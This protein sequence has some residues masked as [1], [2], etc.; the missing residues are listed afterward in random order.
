MADAARELIIIDVQEKGVAEA[1]QKTGKLLSNLDKLDAAQ[2]K[3]AASSDKSS[4]AHERAAAARA[5]ADAAMEKANRALDANARY[6]ALQQAATDAASGS[7][8]GMASAQQRVVDATQ[9]ATKAAN[10]NRDAVAQQGSAFRDAGKFIAEHP[11]LVLGAS[12]AAARALAGLATSAAGS[13]GAASASTAAFAEGAAGMG[14]AVVASAALAA[15]GLSGLSTGATA[16]AAG[17]ETYAAKVAGLTT[18]TGLLARGLAM[19]PPLFLPIAAAFAVFEVGSS[20]IGKANADLDRLIALG[21]RAEKLDVS[22]PFVKA[23]EGLAPKIRASTDAMDAALSKAS[24]FLKDSWGSG[25]ALSKLFGDISATGAAG[26][27]GLQATALSD[28]A[29]TTEERIRAALAGM[30]ELDEL[31]L[32]LASL[33]V[34]EKVFGPEFMERVRTGQ[35]SIAQIVADLDSAVQKEVLKQ[36]QVDRAVAL[37]RQIDD[38]KRAISDALAVNLDWSAAAILLNEAW[39]KILQAVRWIV[40]TMNEG[41]AAVSN[42]ASAVASGIG[43]AFDAVS[44]KVT[45]LLTQMGVLSA[46]QKAATAEL[47]KVDGSYGPQQPTVTARQ[48]PY[49]FGPTAPTYQQATAGAKQAKEAAQEAASAY[50]NLLQKTKDRIEELELETASVGKDTDAVTRLK[51]AHDLERAAKKDGITVTQAMRDETD[52]LGISLA[53]STDNLAKAKRGLEL[54]RDAQRDLAD[55]FASFADSVI[56][57]GRKMGEAFSDLAKTLGSG[58]LRALLTGQGSLAGLFGTAGEKSGDLGGLLGGR[59][60][61][62]FSSNADA[63]GSP[64]AGAQ[65]PSLPTS[66][67]FGNLFNTDKIAD[68]LGFGAETGLG[69]A[70]TAALKEQKTNGGFWSSQL[71]Q[72]LAAVG[73]GAATGYSSA[74]PTMGALTGALAGAASGNP[75]LA[76]AGP[77]IGSGAMFGK[78]RQKTKDQPQQEQP[79]NDRDQR[80]LAA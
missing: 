41:I 34:G 39:L 8:S 23:F 52:R 60:G 15:R 20:V 61:N 11:I 69:K 73:A 6:L 70:V 21:E 12:V 56:V 4:A 77:P 10:D 51:L 25:N 31:G 18:V 59:L 64:L 33:Q 13:L 22:A 29:T 50:D 27:G 65:G 3:V 2:A 42:F 66:S 72:G 47:P 53:A 75:L 58:S 44:N 37:S 28:T 17:L 48:L 49:V 24:S 57:G 71:G 67:M 26:A 68:A 62:L 80:L 36:E 43:G 40:D 55:D 74:S 1:D 76:V 9:Q 45:G 5:R 16:A 46:Q 38:T 14:P 32:H 63:A 79:A 54:T 78:R 30:K 19:V 7:L 35:T